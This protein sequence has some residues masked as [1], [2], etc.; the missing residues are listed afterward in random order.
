MI[1][2]KKMRRKIP[3]LRVSVDQGADYSQLAEIPE[4]R[5]SI[6]KETLCAIKEGIEKNKKT[7]SLFEVAYSDCYIEL[8]K[9][10]WKPTLEKALNHFIEIEDYD[11]CIEMRDLI[12][13]L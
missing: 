13:K 8:D 2:T 5:E 12:S 7:I 11:K 9:P 3:M 1:K 6:I 4:V 10:K